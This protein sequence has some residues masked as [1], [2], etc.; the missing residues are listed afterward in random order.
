VAREVEALAAS[1]AVGGRASC[2]MLVPA[3]GAAML[4]AP[5]SRGEPYAILELQLLDVTPP[6]AT[7]KE[8]AVLCELRGRTNTED[9]AMRWSCTSRPGVI[10]GAFNG[11]R[12]QWK[13]RFEGQEDDQ[14]LTCQK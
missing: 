6:G 8:G 9:N 7:S 3:G 14:K 2:G 5:F 10:T 11:Y 13:L 12:V 4:A 1:V